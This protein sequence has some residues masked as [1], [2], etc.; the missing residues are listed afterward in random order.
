LRLRG[1]DPS[2]GVCARAYKAA[3]AGGP[4]G[5][6]IPLFGDTKS[7]VGVAN[8]TFQCDVD[9]HCPCGDKK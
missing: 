4:P 2:K 8:N 7:P 9:S 1:P 5:K 3:L 6:L